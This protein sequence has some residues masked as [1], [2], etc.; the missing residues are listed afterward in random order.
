VIGVLPKQCRSGFPP[1]A[2][3]AARPRLQR[4]ARAGFSPASRS[5]GAPAPEPPPRL[6]ALGRSGR[7]PS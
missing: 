1:V 2:W 7:T 5:P 3:F 6:P 4:R